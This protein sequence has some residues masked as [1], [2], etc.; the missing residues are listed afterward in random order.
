MNYLNLPIRPEFRTETPYGA[1]QLAVPVRLNTNENPYSPSPALIA[2]L[3]RHVETHAADLNRYPD[4]DC[5]A[6]R[7]DL[8]AY[9][10][11]R[12]GVTVTCANLW[13]ANGSNE[14]LQQLLQIFGGPGRTALGF[15]PSY[16]MHP[17]LAH[18]TGTTFVD[19]PRGADFRIDPQVALAAIADHQPDIVFI[20][21]PNNPTGDVTSLDTIT[22]ILD[23]A[24][25]IVIVDEAYA[26]FSI[27]HID[28]AGCPSR[29]GGKYRWFDRIHCLSV[30][31]LDL[32]C[33][34]GLSAALRFKGYPLIAVGIVVDAHNRPAAP[35]DHLVMLCRR[36]RWSDVDISGETSG[37]RGLTCCIL[38]AP[39]QFRDC[40]GG[41]SVHLVAIGLFL[42]IF[43]KILS[44]IDHRVSVDLLR[45]I[46]RQ[47]NGG[48]LTATAREDKGEESHACT[49]VSQQ[50][51]DT[52][53]MPT[54]GLSSRCCRKERKGCQKDGGDVRDA[55]RPRCNTAKN[56]E[57]EDPVGTLPHRSVPRH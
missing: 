28:R 3:L 17:I 18:G 29:I 19:C 34:E 16:S 51:T 44:A 24:P 23:A 22:R 5:T 21:T 20:A 25:G 14:V 15:Q 50:S 41:R 30:R 46:R 4:R 9:I 10:T 33:D 48:R 7:T 38:A 43:G 11:D 6:L 12:T 2:D 35:Q 1:P 40:F 53:L 27:H 31:Q 13:A 39:A 42:A 55:D 56:G 8:A 49:D 37:N 52:D 45:N 26:E 54:I 57:S 36:R 47:I 32:R